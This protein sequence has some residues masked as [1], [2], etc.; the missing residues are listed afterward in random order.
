MPAGDGKLRFAIPTLIRIP[1]CDASRGKLM[2]CLG[3][4]P[5]CGH[6]I[7]VR[8]MPPP[9]TL[10]RLLISAGVTASAGLVINATVS[11]RLAP[12]P[13]AALTDRAIGSDRAA[14]SPVGP[15]APRQE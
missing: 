12:G 1:R 15:G 3:T 10:P 9:I 2:I 11:R 6:S 7:V 13:V 5:E 14:A 4:L 8:E